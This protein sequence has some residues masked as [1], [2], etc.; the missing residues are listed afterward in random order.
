VNAIT[1]PDEDR[2]RATYGPRKYERLAEIK[3]RY[4][5]GNVF[6]RNANIKPA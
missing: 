2:I 6:H 1:E 5:P 3:G 4:D